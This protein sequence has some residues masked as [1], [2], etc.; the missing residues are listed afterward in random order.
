M[1]VY[2]DFW[3]SCFYF[4][5]SRWHLYPWSQSDCTARL[6]DCLSEYQPQYGSGLWRTY[7]KQGLLWQRGRATG[8]ENPCQFSLSTECS[9]CV[10]TRPKLKEKEMFSVSCVL[11]GSYSVDVSLVLT[12]STA[13][14]PNL[15]R[16][17]CLQTKAIFPYEL[18]IIS[19]E[20][21][22]MWHIT[23]YCPC[24]TRSHLGK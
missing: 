10:D 19:G 13:S 9:F 12:V 8:G 22:H 6:P 2:I 4:S 24:Q 16:G 14:Y 1:F 5:L 17:K 15:M 20:S 3:I 23:G 7:T 11:S 21:G 18:Q